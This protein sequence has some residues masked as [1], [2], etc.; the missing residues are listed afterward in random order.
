MWPFRKKTAQPKVVFNRKHIWRELIPIPRRPLSEEEMEWVRQSLSSRKEFAEFQ[1]PQ[2]FAVSKCPC[3]T[4]RTVG[5]EPF[6][7]P[8]WRGESG[9]LGGITI[10]TK[11]HGPIDILVYTNKG[12]LVEMEVIWYYFPKS[13]P[14]S[15]VEVNRTVDPL[16]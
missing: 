2:L 15:W 3:G 9:H 16:H 13:F 10:E 12:F 8:N 5:L 6:E 4:C 7:L 1:L 14:K 11:D